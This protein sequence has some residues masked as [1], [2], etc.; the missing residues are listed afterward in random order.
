MVKGQETMKLSPKSARSIKIVMQRKKSELIGWTK[1]PAIFLE[2]SSKFV[3]KRNIKELIFQPSFLCQTFST[4][5]GNQLNYNAFISNSACRLG[6]QLVPEAAELWLL[7]SCTASGLTTVIST[8]S[9][10]NRPFISQCSWQM[11]HQC[12][13]QWTIQDWHGEFCNE[14][15]TL[16]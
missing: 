1:I 5:A 14:N 10:D 9:P 11:A 2:M 15:N 7:I 12:M 13:Q 16:K 6:C 3:K 8:R 4:C